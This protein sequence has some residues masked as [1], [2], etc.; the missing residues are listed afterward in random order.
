MWQKFKKGDGKNG[1]KM[2]KNMVKNMDKNMDKNMSGKRQK[3]NNCWFFGSGGANFNDGANFISEDSI[4]EHDFDYLEH[5][6]EFAEYLSRTYGVPLPN[7]PREWIEAQAMNNNI[8]NDM[9]GNYS[10]AP[11]ARPSSV[12]LNID[13]RLTTDAIVNNESIPT[14]IAAVPNHLVEASRDLLI[15]LIQTL[16]IPSHTNKEQTAEERLQEEIMELSSIAESNHDPSH[17][18][19]VNDLRVTSNPHSNQIESIIDSKRSGSKH[20]L[21]YLARTKK[22]NYYWFCH[23]Q[24]DQ[25]SKLNRLIGDYQYKIGKKVNKKSRSR[26]KLRNGKT[27]I[28]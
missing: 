19:I 3:T 13:P 7:F 10:T 8:N 12:D 1:Q 25:D 17:P 24:T 6:M 20:Q 9:Y 15:S 2:I 4:K 27:I 28:S 14:N 16:N 22:G 11:S 23:P 26:K 21:F 5:S 18:R